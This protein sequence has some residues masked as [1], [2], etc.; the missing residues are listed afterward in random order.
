MLFNGFKKAFSGNIRWV[1]FKF[2]KVVGDIFNELHFPS[3]HVL[4]NLANHDA[5]G[6]AGKQ[7]MKDDG[8][9]NGELG[10][11]TPHLE[12]DCGQLSSQPHGVECKNPG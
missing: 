5:E 8:S 9:E 1:V 2:G 4:A 11:V 3:K 6:S 7:E 10:F 12:Y